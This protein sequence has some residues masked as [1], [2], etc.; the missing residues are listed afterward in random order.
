MVMD[1]VIRQPTKQIKKHD[2]MISLLS[3]YRIYRLFSCGVTV[4]MLVS[5]FEVPM[6]NTADNEHQVWE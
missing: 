6:F 5:A 4:A 2:Y 1:K 3:I